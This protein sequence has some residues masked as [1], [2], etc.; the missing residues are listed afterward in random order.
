MTPII[1]RESTVEAEHLHVDV[2]TRKRFLWGMGGF[3]DAMVVYGPGSMVP[4]IYVNALG[5]N[6]ALVNM[7]IA[8][9]RFLDFLTD[10]LIG[11]LSDNTRSRWGRRRPWMLFGLLISAVFGVMLW[12]PPVALAGEAPEGLWPLIGYC[13][14]SPMFWYLAVMMTILFAV[15]YASFSITHAAMGYEMSSDYNERTHLFKW[16][17]CAY[18]V[19]GF[20]TPWLMPLAMWLEGPRAQQLRGS[21]GVIPVSVMIGVLILLAGLPSVLFCKEKLSEHRHEDKVGFLSAVRLTLGNRPFWLLVASNFILKFMMNVTGIFF[22]Y[23]FIYHIAGGQQALG[24]ALVAIFFNSINVTNLLAMAPVAALT[25]RIGKKPALLMMLA[26]SAVAYA[27]CWLTLS[28][29]P[30]AFLNLPLPWGG[31]G[32]VLVLQWPCLITGVLIGMF[33]NTMPMIQ[34]SM[35]ADVCDLD[36]L[37]SGHRREAFY[38]AVFVTTDKIAIAVSLAFQGFLLVYSGF[39]NKLEMQ[40]VG[41]MQFWLL[42]LI[43]TQP[44]GCLIGLVSIFMYPLTRERC[45]VIRAQLNARRITQAPA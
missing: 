20:L 1:E 16:R 6:A 5:V 24:A 7:A 15:G 25:E 39:N 29:A 12:H 28:N 44:L 19:A 18:A 40:A 35:I 10:P 38:G 26:M 45:R 9:P 22:V 17:L 13:A 41:T 34:N 30:G 14:Q 4:V 37:K 36:E 32:N 8:I 2:P 43:I 42:A 33:T 23:V 31:P 21:E 3:A 11:H 27:T